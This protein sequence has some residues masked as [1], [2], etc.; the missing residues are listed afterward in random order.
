MQSKIRPNPGTP[1]AV[2]V[3]KAFTFNE[4]LEGEMVTHAFLTIKLVLRDKEGLAA[5][6]NRHCRCSKNL[7]EKHQQILHV[8]VLRWPAR[9][10]YG[11][12][13]VSSYVPVC[14]LL[15]F[16]RRS[17]MPQLSIMGATHAGT[18]CSHG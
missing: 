1:K 10:S 7:P 18:R 16:F 4:V 6:P 11:V 12:V 13:S 8:G 5:P 9:A 17:G 2:V 3:Q 15:S 14:P